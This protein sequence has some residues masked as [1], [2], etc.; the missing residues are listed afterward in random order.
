MMD[1][2]E[3]QEQE[4]I[5]R[6]REGDPEANY[7]M[8]LWALEQAAAEPDEDR[9]NRLAARCLVKAAEAGYGPAQEKMQEILLQSVA[10]GEID[11]PPAGAHEKAAAEVTEP[12]YEAPVSDTN[13]S[14]GTGTN[15]R[16]TRRSTRSASYTEPVYDDETPQD[17]PAWKTGA[18]N[19]LAAVRTGAVN[20]GSKI[21]ILWFKIFHSSDEDGGWFA[22]AARKIKFLDTDDW[23]ETKWKNVKLGC[24]IV[25]II[26]ALIIAIIIST[27]RHKTR[28]P[29]EETTDIPVA[30]AVETV[31][32]TPT[33]TPYVQY[34]SE[35]VRAE[36]EAAS[37][38]VY[39]EDDDYV[40][41][42]TTRTVSASGGL[43]MRTGPSQDYNTIT[44]IDYNTNVKVYAYIDG[45]ALVQYGTNYGW[46]SGE[47]LS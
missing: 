39:P 8:S 10:N 11:A 9:W 12:A 13:T 16:P 42:S 15:T 40:T 22:A 33:A 37:L 4:M 23:S 17:D 28:E 1:L 38:D 25:C 7:N 19:A 20:L 5:D 3:Q 46:C 18:Q 21:K 44:M 6:A 31:A 14:T 43:R 29:E 27:S 30:D 41:E 45:W 24:V 32:P 26:L 36:I 35:A 47:Y 34:P 2:T